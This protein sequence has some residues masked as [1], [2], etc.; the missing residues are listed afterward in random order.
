M[1]LRTYRAA[2]MYEALA[3]VRRDLGMD[4]AVLH[5]RE[6]RSRGFLG[7]WP[8]RR[9]IEVTASCGVNVP[10][11]LASRARADQA[12]HIEDAASVASESSSAQSVQASAFSAASATYPAE[13]KLSQQVQGQLSTLQAMV[14]DLCRRSKCGDGGHDRDLPDELFRLFTDL[15]DAD[16]SEEVARGLVERVRTEFHDTGFDDPTMLKARVAGMLEAEILVAGPIQVV[17]GRCRVAALIGPTGVGKT[18]TI[19][20]L[21]ANFRLKEKRRVGLITVDT[22]RIAAVEQLRTY[23]DIID[24]P[25]LVV[26]SPREMR[27]AVDRMSHLDLVLMDT[28]GRSPRDEVRVQELRNFLE[29]AA[30]DEVHLVLSSVAATRTLEETA[31]RFTAI[32]ATSLIL[33]KLDEA[34]GLGSVLPMLR[35]SGLPLSYL[36]N[37]QNVPDDIETAEARRVAALILAGHVT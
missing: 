28:A 6:V 1:E 27:E 24:L 37:G 3:L 25:M 5:T 15:L 8:G 29:E 11:R 31:Q 10:S 13:A 17:P 12:A 33:T 2:T 34:T 18:T 32:G 21:A 19:A 36:T 9:Q 26:S 14:K 35:S 7:L 30:A 4:A 23:A 22:Y 16:L 20:K